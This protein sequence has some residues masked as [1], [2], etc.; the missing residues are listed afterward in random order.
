VAQAGSYKG[1]P[2]TTE[3]PRAELTSGIATLPGEDGAEYFDPDKFCPAC[4]VPLVRTLLKKEFGVTDADLAGLPLYST[5]RWPADV[6]SG[7]TLVRAEGSN[8]MDTAAL[9]DDVFVMSM[10]Q[11]AAGEGYKGGLIRRTHT[12]EDALVLARAGGDAEYMLSCEPVR[13]YSRSGAAG[14]GAAGGDDDDGDCGGDGGDAARAAAEEAE[15]ADLT[16]ETGKQKEYRRACAGTY[17]Q[18]VLESG[19]SIC[20]KAWPMVRRARYRRVWGAPHSNARAPR[21][22]AIRGS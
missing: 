8:A 15:E 12:L 10:A 3:C 22:R 2:H 21:S 13:E 11:E 7:A 18:V 16:A 5:F 17:F 14:G 9:K 6:P 19:K 4:V 1:I 20:V